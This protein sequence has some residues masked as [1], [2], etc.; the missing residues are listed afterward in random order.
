MSQI[1]FG[2]QFYTW[3]MSGNRYA[4]KLP[5]ILNIVKPAGFAGIESEPWMLGSYYDD[6]STLKDLLARFNVQLGAIAF[7]CD[8]ANPVET[9][10]EDPSQNECFAMPGHS[11]RRTWSSSRR[12]ETIVPICASVRRT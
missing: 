8:W 12:L 4:G 2:C 1:K 9:E 7:V 6:P 10:Q 11:L 3:Q 5:D